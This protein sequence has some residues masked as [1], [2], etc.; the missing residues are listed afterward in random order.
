[1]ALA[2]HFGKC[3]NSRDPDPRVETLGRLDTLEVAGSRLLSPVSG[4][5]A[6]HTSHTAPHRCS[7]VATH[8]SATPSFPSFSTPSFKRQEHRSAVLLCARPVLL[9]ARPVLL[10]ARSRTDGSNCGVVWNS[11][12]RRVN[13]HSQGWEENMT[14][15]MRRLWKDDEGQDIAEYAVMLAVILVLV[16]GTIRLVGTKSNTVFSNVASSIQ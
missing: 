16:V 13:R 11:E 7:I 15:V 4:C 3:L 8:H 10:C 5:Q 12:C 1:E 6:Q 2:S 14:K 9:C